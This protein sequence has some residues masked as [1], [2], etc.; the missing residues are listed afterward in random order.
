M[1]SAQQTRNEVRSR[2]PWRALRYGVRVPLLLVHAIVGLPLTLLVA[3]R[4]GAKIR[5]GREQLDQRAIR[6]WSAIMC[7]IFGLRLKAYGQAAPDPIMFVANHLSWIDI[8]VIHSQRAASFVGKA[9]IA[10]WPLFG[11]LAKA[12]GT[13]FLQRG[14]AN[15]LNVA[16]EKLADKLNARASVAV[17]PEAGTG[18]G[19]SIRRFHGRLLKAAVLANKPIQPVALRYVRDGNH[20]LTVPFA[21]GENLV[22]NMLRVLGDPACDA[23]LHFLAPI[24]PDG[25][26]RREMAKTAEAMI[27]E[28]YFNGISG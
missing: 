10:S 7:R 6:Y 27:R 23:E 21:A 12:G 4:L 9:E 25:Q 8:Q 17:F 15:S 20:H 18:D 28:A 13:I 5:V 11:W 1:S 26:G 3:N 16:A 14:S 22:Q 19:R 24:T 2:D